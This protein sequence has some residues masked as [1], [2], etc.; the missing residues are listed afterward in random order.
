LGIISIRFKRKL[1]NL[2]IPGI[3]L[4]R[5]EVWVSKRKEKKE[6]LNPTRNEKKQQRHL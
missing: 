5:S 6:F 2:G 3:T 4:A 1:L